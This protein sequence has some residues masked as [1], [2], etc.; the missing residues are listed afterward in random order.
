MKTPYWLRPE[1][2]IC[3]CFCF[4]VSKDECQI[5]NKQSRRA[6]NLYAALR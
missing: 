4:D 1:P 3:F 6:R 5:E 2:E